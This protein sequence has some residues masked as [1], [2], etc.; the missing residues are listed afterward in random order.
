MSKRINETLRE[1]I[2]KRVKA[3]EPRTLPAAEYGM[4]HETV[5]RIAIG[6]G[7]EERKRERSAWQ[8]KFA[9]A[10]ANIYPGDAERLRRQQERKDAARRERGNRKYYG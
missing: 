4:S 5:R 10:W 8:D 6:A 1:T 2:I 3:G 7:N 9:A